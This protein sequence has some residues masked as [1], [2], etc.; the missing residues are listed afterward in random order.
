MKVIARKM[1]DTIEVEIL[2]DGSLKISA[3]SIS[4]AN[5]GTAEALIRELLTLAG[6]EIQRNKK[7]LPHHHHHEHEH[8]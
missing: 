3:D 7:G 2:D 5:H 8:Y 1:N 4:M 6:G